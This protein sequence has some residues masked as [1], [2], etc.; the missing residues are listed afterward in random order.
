M[1]RKK[2]QTPEETLIAF[3]NDLQRIGILSGYRTF[4]DPSNAY[5]KSYIVNVGTGQATTLP[6]QE[7]TSCDVEPF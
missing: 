3:L 5:V 4:N 2:S 1:A 6:V 7:P